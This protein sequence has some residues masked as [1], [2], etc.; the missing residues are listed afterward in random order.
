M[1]LAKPLLLQ[2]AVYSCAP[3]SLCC[4]LHFVFW[5]RFDSLSHCH[6]IHGPTSILFVQKKNTLHCVFQQAIAQFYT[7]PTRTVPEQCIFPFQC[8]YVNKPSHAP[9]HNHITIVPSLSHLVFRENHTPQTEIRFV[10]L[11]GPEPALFMQFAWRSLDSAR[12]GFSW[13][14]DC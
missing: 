5:L 12:D 4:L 8:A 9:G 10:A 6:S 2:S 14:S 11:P 7:L 3:F 13:V 1:A